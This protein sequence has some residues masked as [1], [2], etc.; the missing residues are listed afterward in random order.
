[1][2]LTKALELAKGEQATIYTDS[3]YAFATAHVHGVIQ[4]QRGL[5]TSTGRERL[6]TKKK[7]LRLWSAVMLPR[8]DQQIKKPEQQH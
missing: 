2:A 5:L 1:M 6:K 3:C 7:I 4:Q 8:T